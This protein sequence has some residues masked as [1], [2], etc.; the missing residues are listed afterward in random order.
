MFLLFLG[1]S[2]TVLVLIILLN[3]N[4][5]QGYRNSKFIDEYLMDEKKSSEKG[6]TSK[7]HC[8][9][10]QQIQCVSR[11]LYESQRLL[12]TLRQNGWNNNWMSGCFLSDVCI[13]LRRT[14]E[15]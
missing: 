11:K 13:A 10:L 6:E 9:I 1:M 8:R 5:W 12:Q 14:Y 2:F 7:L 4:F 15:K 3:P